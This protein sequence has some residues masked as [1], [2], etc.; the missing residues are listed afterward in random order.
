MPWQAIVLT[1]QILMLTVG[2]ILFQQARTELTARAAEAPVL[3]EIK[4]L[5]RSVKQLLAEI[6]NASDENSTRLEQRCAEARQLI[7]E[8]DL[9][10]DRL[11]EE[12]QVAQ[13][14]ARRGRTASAD[15]GGRQREAADRPAVAVVNTGQ[16]VNAPAAKNGSPLKERVYSLADAGS[17]AAEIARETSLSEGE[18]ET[19]LG[20][21]VQRR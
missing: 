9:R 12:V 10:L 13:K 6:Q 19:L 16:S 1:V 2:W 18:V 11:T 4:A 14:P 17:T 20:L 3:S 7:A 8:L 15:A 21:R 5:Q